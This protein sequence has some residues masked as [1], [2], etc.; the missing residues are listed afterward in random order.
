MGIRGMGALN[1]P[2]SRA[3][4]TTMLQDDVE[5][6]RLAA[7]EELAR[8]GDNR[9][10]EEVLAYFKTTPDLNKAGIANGMAVMAIGYLKSDRLNALLPQAIN[11]SNPYIQLLAAQSVLLQ[12]K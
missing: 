5:E 2:E 12:V 7:A 3:A 10:E 8:L 1:T 9:G 11:S 4:I 6:V